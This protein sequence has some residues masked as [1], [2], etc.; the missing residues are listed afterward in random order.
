MPTFTTK[1]A[2]G[3]KAW[4]RLEGTVTPL[5]LEVEY[6]TLIASPFSKRD[7]RAIYGF[8]GHPLSPFPEHEVHRTKALAYR[9]KAADVNKGPDFIFPA[10]S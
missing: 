10:L 5:K 2:P 4:V 8:K 7:I 6:I 1:F 3:D 9:H